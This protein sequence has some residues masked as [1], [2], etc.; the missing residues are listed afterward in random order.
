MKKIYLLSLAVFT[1]LFS[2]SQQINRL[3]PKVA[4]GPES[5]MH[6][7]KEKQMTSATIRKAPQSYLVNG[8][9]LAFIDVGTSGNAYG[10]YG[11]PRSFLWTDDHI[12]SVVFTHRMID[13]PPVPGQIGYAVSWDNG[14][15]GSW[16]LDNLV[17]DPP[18]G[19]DP[20]RYPQGG[21]INS[22]G[23][24]NPEDAIFTYFSPV[25][26]NINGNWGGYA[27]GI[28]FLTD[29]NPTNPTQHVESGVP[30]YRSV[31]SAFTITQTGISWV[32]DYSYDMVNAIYTGELIFYRGEMNELNDD[33]EYEWW[34]MEALEEEDIINDVKIAFC[35]S[36][37]NGY[38]NFGYTCVVSDAASDP[39]PYTD[40]HPI[41]FETTDGGE[42]WSDIPN[43]C[44]LGGPDGLEEIKNYLPD[45]ILDALFPGGWDRDTLSYNLGYRTGF[46]VDEMGNAHCM[47]IVAPSTEEGWFPNQ[48]VMGTFHIWYDRQMESWDA[49]LLYM[50]RAFTG[51]LSGL[52]MDNRPYISTDMNGDYLFF[53]WIDTDQEGLEENISP[54]IYSVS[55]YPHFEDPYSE[56]FNVTAFTQA[57]WMA[58]F[59]SQSHFVFT[60]FIN[61][62]EEILC[63]VPFVY[64]E[65]DPNDPAAEVTFWYIGG[66]TYT[67]PGM[68]RIDENEI[69]ILIEVAQNHPNPFSGQTRIDVELKHNSNLSLEVY[70]LTGQKIIEIDKGSVNAGKHQFEINASNMSRGVYFYQ[71]QAGNS[72]QTKK[73]ILK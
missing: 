60:E 71:V 36:L 22:P 15:T 52:T 3:M 18:M 11:E 37:F 31:P 58:Y 26:S 35:P 14:N 10:F 12:N 54:D 65:L 24:T 57:M 59:A 9:D 42:T 50:N 38:D 6:V 16:H 7:E 2:Y 46:Q 44:Q 49:H 1:V 20:A 64:E 30:P 55:Y 40:F 41:L 73:M 21:I 61:N 34:T 32:V 67:F 33:I 19:G 17:Y 8:R 56:V 69:S 53:S 5:F 29:I 27:Y 23:N 70:N 72:I 47:G 51:D 63:T 45:E 48:D 13:D 62:G 4:P 25:L 43:H 68:W 39:I 66:F 28:N